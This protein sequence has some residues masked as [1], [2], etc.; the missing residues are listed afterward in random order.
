MQRSIINYEEIHH[1]LDE[2]IN[3]KESKY[4]DK[5][6]FIYD[7]QSDRFIYFFNSNI[8]IF[9]SKGTLEKYT[10]VELSETIKLAA[11]EYTYN[12]LLLLTKSNQG[13]ICELDFEK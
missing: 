7:K 5:L 12:F 3:A 6:Y 2:M 9:N 8:F 10:K 4:K 13:I 11:V 1:N